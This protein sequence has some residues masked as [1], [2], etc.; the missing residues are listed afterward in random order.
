MSQRRSKVEE[1][2]TKVLKY[3]GFGAEKFYRFLLVLL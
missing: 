3:F 1:I 2:Y